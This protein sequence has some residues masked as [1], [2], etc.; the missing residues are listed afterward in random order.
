MTKIKL[1]GLSRKEDIM[2]ANS[3]SPDYIGFVFAKKSIRYVTFETAAGLKEIL[4]PGILSVG[5]FVDED[6]KKV[7]EYL[8]A[9]VIDLAQLHGNENDDYIRELRKLTDKPIIKAFRIG[10]KDDLKPAEGSSADHILLDAGMGDGKVFE[11]SWLKGIS[12]PY[13]LAGGLNTGNVAD[14]VNMLH[15]FA[16][17]VS[18]GIETEGYKDPEK[19]REF[20]ELVRHSQNT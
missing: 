7:S 9:G 8:T 16:V 3:V 20:T 10:S 18:S 4:A 1:C 15:P 19:M 6:V 11:W 14:A 5:V 13:F 12:R 2:A 17:D